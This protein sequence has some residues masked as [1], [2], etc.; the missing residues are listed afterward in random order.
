MPERYRARKLAAPLRRALD[1][2]AAIATEEVLAAHVGQVL[3]LIELADTRVAP[4]RVADI[5]LRLHALEDPTAMVIRTRVLADLGQRTRTGTVPEVAVE[6]D[7]EESPRGPF[8]GLRERFR[9]R[10]HHD[11]RRWMELQTGRS[12]VMLL[13]IH[14]R[15]ALVFVRTLAPE[16]PIHEAVAIYR[17]QVGAR[18]QLGEVLYWLV[19]SRLADAELPN[20]RE[21]EPTDLRI[22]PAPRKVPRRNGS[23]RTP[24]RTI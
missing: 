21:I 13:D 14:V 23:V 2:A 15:N 18:E 16:V 10:V 1:V 3:E 17:E 20:L 5:Y 6:D 24:Y 9:G 4:Q 12:E 11:L 8:R 22:P 7:T 19:L